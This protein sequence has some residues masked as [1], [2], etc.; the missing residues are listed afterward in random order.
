MA[1]NDDNLSCTFGPGLEDL[2]I[3]LRSITLNGAAQFTGAELSE[4]STGLL[5]GEV[6]AVNEICTATRRLTR[7][8]RNAGYVFSRAY[9]P[10]QDI[11]EG[12]L[13]FHFQA[14]RIG[15]VRI[16]GGD[17]GGVL[18]AIGEASLALDPYDATV[19]TEPA[20]LALGDRLP[21]VNGERQ[22][23]ISTTALADEATLEDTTTFV[24]S[25]LPV[26][27]SPRYRFSVNNRGSE[28]N[29][30]WALDASATF[31][32]VFAAYDIMGVRVL[33]SAET[34]ELTY[35]SIA[36]DYLLYPDGTALRLRLAASRSEPGTPT[37]RSI[38][39]ENQSQSFSLTWYRPVLR[40]Q[41]TSLA[42]STTFDWR[43][44]S[45]KQLGSPATEDRLRVLRF[46]IEYE[47]RFE[48]SGFLQ[49][50]GTL[51]QGIDGLGAT[52]ASNLLATRS[53]GEPDF[54][55][56]E[57]F[58]RYGRAFESG[59]RVTAQLL[60]QISTA[61]LLSAEECGL[62]GRNFGRAFNSSEITGDQ[63]IAAS[64][65]V[66]YRLQDNLPNAIQ[67]LEPYTFLDGGRVFNFGSQA[68]AE[69]AS[70]GLGLRAN[71]NDALSGS[72]EIARPLGRDSEFSGNREPRV[73]IGLS[74]AF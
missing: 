50:F 3:T 9:L 69:L 34:G 70:F 58:L 71:F 2:T 25:R 16:E 26:D 5:V 43:N 68:D 19:I 52:P 32:E 20:S 65:E 8:I 62:G 35:A 63:C 30:P 53:D 10:E 7:D 14:V 66:G 42:F 29:G 18:A 15:D 41:T 1:P 6:I 28:A 56:M 46:G 72:I 33:Q 17:P 74:A 11:T 27:T 51:S 45:S 64:V 31:Y 57:A 55:S 13:T 22:N 61:P 67:S 40:T 59:V 60:G 48:N 44:S 12:N 23:P 24:L 49:V 4:A 54:T 39:E 73:Y 38:D 36:Y 47:R 37:L 21:R